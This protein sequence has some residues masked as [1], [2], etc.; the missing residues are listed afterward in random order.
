MTA[1]TRKLVPATDT[2]FMPCTEAA[3]IIAFLET[4]KRLGELR[5]IENTIDALR[6]ASIYW[7]DQS[8]D[9]HTKHLVEKIAV[10]HIDEFLALHPETIPPRDTIE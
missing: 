8:L 3:L 10:S 1:A 9:G 6:I 5:A 2:Q 4:P 7:E